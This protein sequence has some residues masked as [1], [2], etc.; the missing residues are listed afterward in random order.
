[1]TQYLLIGGF[2]STLAL[3]GC[4]RPVIVTTQPTPVAVPGPAGP[5]GVAGNQGNQGNQG[6]QGNDGNQGDKGKPGAD[7]TTVIVTQPA[8]PPQ[9]EPE[10]SPKQTTPN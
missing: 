9:N 5:Q 2:L 6:S 7:T 1:M 8:P 4:E 10:M 3:T